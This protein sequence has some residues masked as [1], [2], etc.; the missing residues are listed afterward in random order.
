MIT[1]VHHYGCF[2]RL[3]TGGAAQF[4]N[5]KPHNPSTEDWYIPGDMEEGNYLMMDPAC[6]LNEKDTRE[7]YDGNEALEEGTSPPL[8]LDSNEIIE[9]DEETLPY[10]E[11]NWENPEQIEVPKRI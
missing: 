6:E 5:I 10:A 3:G 4:E 11:N 8:D 7:K 9:A 1:K 2:Y